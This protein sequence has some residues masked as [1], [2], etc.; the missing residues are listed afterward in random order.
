MTLEELIVQLKTAEDEID[1]MKAA[2]ELSSYEGEE[3]ILALI[4]ALDD[5]DQLVAVAATESLTKARPNPAPFLRDA[6]WSERLSVRWGAAELLV[7]FPSSETE[8]ALRMAL[9]DP[10]TSVRGAAARALRVM[11]MDAETLAA[12]KELVDDPDRFVR[13]EALR[14]LQALAP[15][16]V[17]EHAFLQRDLQSAEAL[18]RAEAVNYIR[19][20]GRIEWLDEIACLREDPDF[21]VRRAADSAWA[22]LQKK[23]ES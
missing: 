3:V 4:D 12:L 18:S 14:T 23:N 15:Q 8:A 17:D 16:L 9:F 19:D 22:R 21:R 6:L 1:R 7:D 10:A 20:E 11:A 2:E 13:Y 5:P